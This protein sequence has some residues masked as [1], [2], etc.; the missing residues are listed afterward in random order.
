MAKS[1]LQKTLEK[2]LG[3]LKQTI[4]I[5]SLVP[6]IEFLEKDLERV[7]NLGQ[8]TSL[9][10]EEESNK[11]G[12]NMLAIRRIAESIVGIEDHILKLTEQIEGKLQL[13]RDDISQIQQFVEAFVLNLQQQ[14]NPHINPINIGDPN[15]IGDLNN[16][17]GL[18]RRK[19][20][21]H[22]KK[23]IRRRKSRKH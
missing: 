21:T 16:A 23:K 10:Q 1:E 12:K 19:R 5:D 8:I 17:E 4:S 15:N 20:K 14:I 3:S 2:R 13:A 7:R 18:R 6:R 22:R 11:I 9:A